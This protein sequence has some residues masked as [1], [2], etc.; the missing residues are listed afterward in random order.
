MSS[1]ILVAWIQSTNSP[2]YFADNE[3]IYFK[4]FSIGPTPSSLTPINL[5]SATAVAFITEDISSLGGAGIWSNS[6]P[7]FKLL[8]WSDDVF[9]VVF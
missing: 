1:G 8:T 9:A 5:F 6:V 3:N 4:R 7:A 2:P